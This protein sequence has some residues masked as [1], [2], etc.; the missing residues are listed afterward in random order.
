MESIKSDGYHQFNT[1]V[2]ENGFGLEK[3]W[4]PLKKPELFSK[5]IQLYTEQSELA[6]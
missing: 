5:L 6:M 3:G 2:N 1:E 4:L